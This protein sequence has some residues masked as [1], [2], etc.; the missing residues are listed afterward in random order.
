MLHPFKICLTLA[1]WIEDRRGRAR[2]RR[3]TEGK[4][5]LTFL[6]QGA[7]GGMIGY[8]FVTVFA[9]LSAQGYSPFFF[10]VLPFFL[11][12]GGVWGAVA[13]FFVWLPG[14]LLKRRLGFLSRTVCAIGGMSLLSAA[15]FYG[16]TERLDNEMYAWLV[17]YL[18]AV[19]LPIILMTG[20]GIR[21]G[22]ALVFGAGGHIA[23]L[24]FRHWLAVPPGF[25]LR[26]ASIFGVLEALLA[27]AVWISARI[28]PWSSASAREGLPA[29]LV[30]VT[31]FV[32]STYFS[33]RTPRKIV[34]LPLAIA[35][36]M[37]AAFLMVSEK[38]LGTPN[39]DFLAYTYLGFICL[40]LVYTL[41]CL[42]APTATSPVARLVNGTFTFK[43]YRNATV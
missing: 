26:A 33:L 10:V 27:L 42:I 43:G 34:L 9:A 2:S 40:W 3:E 14:A 29:I 17:G 31:Y 30:A 12:F 4:T 5:I 16:R 6:S 15:V 37:P 25:L 7:V 22:R 32:T 11:V 21:P 35:L 18:C 24:R 38:Q 23:R 13:G 8:F 20:S 41:G 28:S 39:S 36:N 1:E 19:Y